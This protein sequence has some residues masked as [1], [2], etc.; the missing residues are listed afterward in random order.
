MKKRKNVIDY[1]I[2]A[3]QEFLENDPK[4]VHYLL[5]LSRE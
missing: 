5:V 4:V 2:G 3:F 1:W